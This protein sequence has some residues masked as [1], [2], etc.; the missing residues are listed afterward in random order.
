MSKSLKPSKKWVLPLV[1]G[2]IFLIGI[3]IGVVILF[4]SSGSD[5]TNPSETPSK[6]TQGRT[7]SSSTDQNTNIDANY[8]VTCPDTEVRTNTATI[9][10]VYTDGV[11]DVQTITKTN[12]G[13]E[14]RVVRTNADQTE[15]V[16][17]IDAPEVNA[18]PNIITEYTAFTSTDSLNHLVI[19]VLTSTETVTYIVPFVY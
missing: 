18:P 11:S 2:S 13:Y 6:F 12:T 9:N 5:N 1:I 3:I 17:T 16:F 19:E 4:A 8:C 14:L 10:R 15:T 7:N